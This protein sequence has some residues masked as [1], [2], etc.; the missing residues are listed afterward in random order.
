LAWNKKKMA[1]NQKIKD[2]KKAAEAK[3]E[4]KEKPF[5]PNADISK[6]TLV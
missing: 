6:M 2:A 5:D 4:P 1:H 3:E